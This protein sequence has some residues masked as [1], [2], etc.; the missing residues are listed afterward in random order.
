MSIYFE[1]PERTAVSND[2]DFFYEF[3]SPYSF[4][5]AQRL[6]ALAARIGRAIRWRPIELQKVWAAQGILEAYGTIRRAKRSYILMDIQ[7]TADDLGIGLKLPNIPI[8]ATLARLSVYGLE[9][10]APG[11]GANFTLKLWQRLWGQGLSISTIDDMMLALPDGVNQATLIAAIEAPEALE[12]LNS[13]N[14]DA[15]ASSC[16][17]VPWLLADG[18]A[19]FGQDRLEILE[20]RLARVGPQK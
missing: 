4:I 14:A 1:G 6:P 10:S 16:F 13:A 2:I 11:L 9:A 3:A 15:I 7:R 19:C 12:H 18:G 8:D 20:R 5:A 17:G